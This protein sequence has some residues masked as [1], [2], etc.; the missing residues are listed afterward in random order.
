MTR[1]R[2]ALVARMR[3]D[4]ESGVALLSA[5]MF[6]V[7][8]A[9]I[10]VV[11]LSTVLGQ[12][13]PSNLAQRNTKTIYA[14]QAGVQ[15]SLAMLRSASAPADASGKVYGDPSKL[16][17]SLTG[18]VDAQANGL[19]Y[20]ATIKYY[21]ADPTKITGA[22][23]P[24]IACNAAGVSAKP[25]FAQI[26]SQGT[27]DPVAGVSSTPTGSR[28]LSAV[29]SFQ[30]TNINIPGGRIFDG[31]N[32]YCLEAMSASAGANIKFTSKGNCVKAKEANQLWVYNTDYEIALASTTIAGSTPLC[33]TGPKNA[34]EATQNATLT[35]CAAQQW[36]QLWSWT[37]DYTWQ[38]QNT[39]ITKGYSSYYLAGTFAEGSYL[40][41]S[42]SRN[43]TFNP[44]AAVGAGAASAKTLQI[45][46]YLEF[47]R[48]LDVTNEQTGSAFM[49]SYP[50]KQDPSGQG[51][52]AGTQ[53]LNWNHKWFYTEPTP[54]AGNPTGPTTPLTQT[55]SVLYNNDPAQRFCL[56]TATNSS[57]PKYPVLRGCNGSS[58][59]NWTRVNNT[60]T[61]A[62]SYLFVDSSG[63][64]LSVGT[65]PSD[66]FGTPAI[67]SKIVVATCDNSLAQ[68]WNAPAAT[69]GGSVGSYQEVYGG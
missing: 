18:S 40:Q 34:G 27:A 63:L 51:N 32:N 35:V 67:I 28:S 46:N 10:S 2:D 69:V 38:G 22:A 65:D 31:N 60:G 11:L 3:G 56:Q 66:L 9:G 62:N 24:Q 6:M 59:Q 13:V 39:D 14:A 1:L 55:I 4:S 37:G 54:P 43:G 44:L 42:T 49:I 52:P 19:S 57:G 25:K 12:I 26:S 47:G 29:Y 53:N 17:C 48:C 8:M 64:C 23:N 58:L 68:K 30:I 15:A 20:V 61:Y 21:N 33:I 5:I 45:V 16:L 36:N 41:V 7:I 50:C